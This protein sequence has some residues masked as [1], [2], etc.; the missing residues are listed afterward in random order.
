MDKFVYSPEMRA[1]KSPQMDSVWPRKF[2]L[3]VEKS[4]ITKRRN[5][6]RPRKYE[7]NSD[8]ERGNP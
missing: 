5:I 3:D 8:K 7:I 4:Y 6:I 1:I 2:R